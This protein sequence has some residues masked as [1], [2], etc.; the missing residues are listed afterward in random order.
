MRINLFVLLPVLLL[1][2]R[3]VHAQETVQVISLFQTMPVPKPS[4]REMMADN[5]SND[6]V[7]KNISATFGAIDHQ[8]NVLYK[9][10]YDRFKKA[11]ASPGNLK[12]TAAEQKMIKDIRMG[13]KGLAEP[14]QLD[15]FRLQMMY[16][17]PVGSGR[18]MWAFEGAGARSPAAQKIYQKLIKLEADFNWNVFLSDAEKYVPKFGS[19]NK[20]LDAVHKKFNDDLERLP[21][22][23]QTL[24]GFTHE[25]P[26][27]DK[28]IALCRSYGV[29]RQQV[30][31]EEYAST[32]NWWKLH[33]QKLLAGAEILDALALELAAMD[34]ES[35]RSLQPFLTDLQIRTLE[36]LY[37]LTAVT[38]RLYNDRLV[39]MI[40]EQQVK[41]MIELYK[42]YKAGE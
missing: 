38:Q 32:Y 34:D 11:M 13:A 30:F 18:P 6:V 9:P 23:K 26:D 19:T 35:R 4:L 15:F 22:K 42:H 41:E 20:A 27:P 14:L 40:G 12:L 31:G 36:A 25:T 10:V 8:V 28:A 37:K 33:Y 17:L 24:S 3:S 29:Q 39:G 1:T 21:K 16:R 5:T 2:A 7:E